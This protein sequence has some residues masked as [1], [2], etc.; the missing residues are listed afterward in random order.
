MANIFV[1]LKSLILPLIVMILWGSLFPCVKIGYRVF[2]IA[3]DNIPDIIASCD[4]KRAG[5]TVPAHGLYLNRVTFRN[6]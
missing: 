1:K 6:D 4:R 5:I 2:N 3:G